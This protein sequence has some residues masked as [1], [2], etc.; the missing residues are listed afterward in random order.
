MTEA[1]GSGVVIGKD[2][3]ARPAWAATDPL[4]REYY[5]SE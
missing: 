5:D 4:L 2:G 3:L 1:H